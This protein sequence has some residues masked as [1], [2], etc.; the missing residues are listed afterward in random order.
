MVF[1]FAHGFDNDTTM[2]QFGVLAACRGKATVQMWKKIVSQQLDRF[3]ARKVLLH[4]ERLLAAK[5][6]LVVEW[7]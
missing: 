1:D 4:L 2:A 7:L 3:V 5:M 6:L